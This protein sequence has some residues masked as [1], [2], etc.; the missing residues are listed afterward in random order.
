MNGNFEGIYV[1]SFLPTKD[2]IQIDSTNTWIEKNGSK[3]VHIVNILRW[4]RTFVMQVTTPGISPFQWYHPDL[5][6]QAAV[7]LQFML[8]SGYD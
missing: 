1:L 7:L 5:L 2:M 3:W 8:L 6:K 4:V